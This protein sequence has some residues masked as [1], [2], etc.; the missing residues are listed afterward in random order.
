M[1][2]LYDLPK[3]I[4]VKL[5]S[6]IKYDTQFNERMKFY[7]RISSMQAINWEDI[8]T[9]ISWMK[10]DSKTPSD[11][12]KFVQFFNLTVYQ[13]HMT[14]EDQNKY[15]LPNVK[16]T[17]CKTWNEIYRYVDNHKYTY[18]KKC[19]SLYLGKE[20]VCCNQKI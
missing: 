13:H 16:N 9:L 4:L 3:D 12:L 17:E 8:P 1:T 11:F 2:N 20:Y 10:E 14:L 19:N 7:K 15:L 5:I 18:C 6:E